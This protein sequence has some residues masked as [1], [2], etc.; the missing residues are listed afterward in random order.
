MQYSLPL[1]MEEISSCDFKDQPPPHC[2]NLHPDAPFLNPVETEVDTLLVVNL[3][4]KHESGLMG[5]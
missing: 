2:P 5:L 3:Q 1:G 4:P